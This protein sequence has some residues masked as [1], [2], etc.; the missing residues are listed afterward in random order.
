MIIQMNL[1]CFLLNMPPLTVDSALMH[2]KRLKAE[3]FD[4]HKLYKKCPTSG[5][6]R[7][8]FI[9]NIDYLGLHDDRFFIVIKEFKYKQSK[10][11]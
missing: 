5:K 2:K 1:K 4:R 8:V 6:F 3:G 11:A 10:F 9:C 7:L